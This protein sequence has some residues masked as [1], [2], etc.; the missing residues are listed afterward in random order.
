M[1]RETRFSDGIDGLSSQPVIGVG[2][3]RELCFTWLLKGA[4]HLLDFSLCS[5]CCPVTVADVS[6]VTYGLCHG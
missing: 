4:S 3:A 1:W 2:A 5:T 6:G